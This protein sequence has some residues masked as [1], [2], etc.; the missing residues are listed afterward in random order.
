MSNLYIIYVLLL[1]NITNCFFIKKRYIKMLNFDKYLPSIIEYSD[2]LNN[3]RTS[4]NLLIDSPII[5]KYAGM[6]MHI[7]NS[8]ELE[9]EKQLIQKIIKQQSLFE[10]L[11]ILESSHSNNYKLEEIKQNP[12]IEDSSP[13]PINIKSGGLFKDWEEL[14]M[15]W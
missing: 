12:F 8:E 3:N 11:I 4:D 10:L 5:H 1:L 6:D 15:D 7:N 9:K 2:F 14:D 13:R